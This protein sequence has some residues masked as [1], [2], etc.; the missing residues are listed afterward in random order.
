MNDDIL[1]HTR[2]QRQIEDYLKKPSHALLIMGP[3]GAGKSMVARFLAAELLQ[4]P[5]TA[6][7]NQPFFIV[8]SKQDGKSEI[9]IDAVRELI[10]SLKLKTG[11]R[12]RIVV[13]EEAE[14][15]S[16]EAQ[17]ALLKAIEEPPAG[18]TFLLCVPSE[19]S[20]LP[21]I[22][23]R[24]RKLKVLPVAKDDSV[25]YF[26]GSAAEKELLGAWSLSRGA[27]GL[28]T[29]LLNDQTDH[30][31]KR[32]VDEAKKFV[33]LDKFE[34]TIYLDSLVGNKQ[35]LSVFLDALGRV[36]AAISVAV[37]A[38]EQKRQVQKL[39]AARR[40]IADAQVDIGHNVS[41]RL[42]C[43]NLALNLPI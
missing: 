29:A 27:A 18:T 12:R 25:S 5:M 28:M 4:K 17:N 40:Q 23:S 42:I 9:S 37:S 3:P 43:L 36:L 6:L 34:K 2:T 15:L 30:D 13:I 10:R 41:A 1:L 26:A 22:A 7:V 16:E 32:A 11:D 20:V 39:A 33:M 8:I 14:A 24:S 35:K 31:L 38:R 21:T 19:K